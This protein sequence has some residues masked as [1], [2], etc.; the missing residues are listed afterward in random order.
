MHS[1]AACLLPSKCCLHHH[2]F[3]TSLRPAWRWTLAHPKTVCAVV[4]FHVSYTGKT[5]K[6][7]G[8]VDGY[9]YRCM[10]QYYSKWVQVVQ[11]ADQHTWC[12]SVHLQ[13]GFQPDCTAAL[14]QP[15]LSATSKD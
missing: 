11:K 2:L 12:E 3:N 8:K 9:F 4:S 14:L 6:D 15:A 10:L 13:P 5:Q 7:N 1:I